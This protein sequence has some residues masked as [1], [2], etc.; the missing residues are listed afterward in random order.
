MGFLDSVVNAAGSLLNEGQGNGN[1]LD[2]ASQLIK[3]NPN[4]LAGVVEQFRNGGLA[5]AVNS[6]VGTGE[7]QPISAGAVQQ[8]LG[9]TQLGEIAGKFGL[10]SDQISNGLATVLP[11][12]INHLT[13]N[14]EVDSNSNT[15]MDAGLNLLKGKLF[16]A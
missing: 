2:A 10:S 7:N 8:V 12:L 14:G 1:L 13:P 3:D 4:G 16:G 11:E 9:E 5:E 15:L 6:W